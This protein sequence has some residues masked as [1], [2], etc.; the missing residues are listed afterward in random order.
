MVVKNIIFSLTVT[1]FNKH[2]SWA[3]MSYREH[4]IPQRMQINKLQFSLCHL[5]SVKLWIYKALLFRYM[6][7][8]AHSQWNRAMLS[9]Y[10][11]IVENFPQVNH[12]FSYSLRRAQVGR[13]LGTIW[14]TVTFTEYDTS[15]MLADITGS[16]GIYIL[17]KFVILR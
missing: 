5:S 9:I 8:Y 3:S 10:L 16:K 1:C 6:L 4:V 7:T 11:M 2:N 15:S 13:L 17:E 12:F 14:P